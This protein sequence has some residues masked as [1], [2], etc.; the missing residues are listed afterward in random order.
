[1][2]GLQF[3][4][5]LCSDEHF[6]AELGRAVLAAGRLESALKRYLAST[7]SAKGTTNATLGQLIQSCRKS[8]HLTKMVPVLEG[9]RDQRN[10]LTHN[11]HALL[12]D[13][14]GETILERANLLDSDV[15]TYTE[16]ALELKN[17]LN[18]LA[19]IV[20]RGLV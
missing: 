18:A 6:C 7:A 19:D 8:Q 9:L 16:R 15:V 20:E 13:L 17:N 11:I 4:E 12:S 1:M 10:Y 14:I 5:L 3:F 2:D